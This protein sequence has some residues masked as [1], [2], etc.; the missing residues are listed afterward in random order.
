MSQR[1]GRRRYPAW[2]HWLHCPQ[3]GKAYHPE[4]TICPYCAASLV[5]D[6]V[7]ESWLGQSLSTGDGDS[8]STFVNLMR[9]GFGMA[10]DSPFPSGHRILKQLL[11]LWAIAYPILIVLPL[12]STGANNAGATTV[13]L[14]GAIIVGSALF[15]PWIIGIIVLAVLVAVS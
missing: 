14:L 3:C 10:P 9:K 1:R 5:D 2:S 12:I 6:R 4:A 13:G 15:F 7:R 8:R 11:G